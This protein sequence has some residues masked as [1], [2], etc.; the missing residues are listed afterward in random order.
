MAKGAAE[1]LLPLSF[2]PYRPLARSEQNRFN[3]RNADQTQLDQKGRG[4]RTDRAAILNA[5]NGSAG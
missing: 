1:A 5:P 2:C 3:V 4:S